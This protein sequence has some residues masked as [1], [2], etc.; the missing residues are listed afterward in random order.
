[1]AGYFKRPCGLV[2]KALVCGNKDCRPESCQGHICGWH[3]AALRQS[4]S[5][6]SLTSKGSGRTTGSEHGRLQGEKA[7]L[8]DGSARAGQG[9]PGRCAAPVQIGARQQKGAGRACTMGAERPRARHACGGCGAVI[10]Y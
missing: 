4:R 10:A 1:M 9:A 3:G 2:D 5:M 6:F 7:A 8:P